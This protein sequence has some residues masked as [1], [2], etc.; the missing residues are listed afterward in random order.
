[1][2]GWKAKLVATEGVLVGGVREHVSSAFESRESAL[3]WVR[4]AIQVNLDSK[5]KVKFVGM[6]EVNFVEITDE[7]VFT[8]DN[9]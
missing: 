8:T 9:N 1:M 2:H 4:T 3:D 7:E 5:R 6:V